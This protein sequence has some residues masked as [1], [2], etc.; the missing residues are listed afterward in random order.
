MENIL[1]KDCSQYKINVYQ[2]GTRL[3]ECPKDIRQEIL[4]MPL[5]QEL[6]S[7]IGISNDW[8]TSARQ[9]KWENVRQEL[10]SND[11]KLPRQFLF[12]LTSIFFSMYPYIWIHHPNLPNIS[13]ELQLSSTYPIY[14]ESI[15]KIIYRRNDNGNN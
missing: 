7:T 12:N 8:L 15:F 4:G 2:N 3:V 14:V 9:H 10:K 5:I 1:V 13:I 6:F 11:W